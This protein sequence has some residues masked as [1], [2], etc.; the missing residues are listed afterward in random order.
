MPNL[1]GGAA[2][3]GLVVALLLVGAAQQLPSRTPVELAAAGPVAASPASAL[4]P[5]VVVANLP[6][7]VLKMKHAVKAA[8]LKKAAAKPAPAKTPAAKH[9]A[10]DTAVH[11]VESGANK[12]L[13]QAT[14]DAIQAALM[15]AALS[16]PGERS[17]EKLVAKEAAVKA[18]ALPSAAWL[19]GAKAFADRDPVPKAVAPKPRK[20]AVAS[21]APA[22]A[23]Q[24]VARVAAV[25][26]GQ[27]GKTALAGEQPEYIKG[28]RAVGNPVETD[29]LQPQWRYGTRNPSKVVNTEDR[30]VPVGGLMPGR[31]EGE[32]VE[33][34][35][36]GAQQLAA[37][38][39]MT[40]LAGEQPE[41]IKGTREVGNAVETDDLQPQ[42][43]YGTRNPS[44]VVNTEDRYVPVGGLMP[45]NHAGEEVEERSRGAQQL[46]TRTNQPNAPTLE[47]GVEV[48]GG[49]VVWL[50]LNS[51]E[52][53][54]GAQPA[55]EGAE[56]A[57]AARGAIPVRDG[58]LRRE[59]AAGGGLQGPAPGQSEV[60][61]PR[62]SPHKYAK[63]VVYGP[64]GLPAY[65][66]Y[67]SQSGPEG[68]RAAGSAPHRGVAR[69]RTHAR[70][71]AATRGGGG[72]AGDGGLSAEDREIENKVLFKLLRAEQTLQQEGAG[73]RGS[74]PSMLLLAVGTLVALLA[75]A[76]SRL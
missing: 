36:R 24:P 58:N 20:A 59:A 50:P 15:R 52:G 7:A 21:P 70:G 33:E 37:A 5:A 31:Q 71:A 17:R 46:A 64:N 2:M 29:D 18:A 11:S 14:T 32:E 74:A 55:A 48:P 19:A 73:A 13:S 9:V 47:G 40:A 30:Y 28:T 6:A 75:G 45:G 34:R 51:L 49:R 39:G 66:L 43:R 38:H 65:A 10:F 67:G 57:Q 22:Q 76:H 61:I 4:H 27:G 3:G 35:S 72:G 8:A 56:G 1:R 26:L 16:V 69:G 23:Q 44:K 42:W 53:N 25:P 63:E 12:A 68:A 41:Y 60:E 62:F 54:Q